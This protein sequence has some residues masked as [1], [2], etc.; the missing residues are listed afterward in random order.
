[1][2]PLELEILI[3]CHVTSTQHPNLD[4]PA[5]KEGFKKF[6]A[7]GIIVLAGKDCY[8]LTEKGRAWLETILSIPY[9][10]VWLDKREVFMSENELCW[11]CKE[12]T[13]RKGYV[14]L[15]P[16]VHCHHEP[17]EK[18]KC[19][20]CQDGVFAPLYRPVRMN[21]DIKA[22]KFCPECGRKP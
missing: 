16:W 14:R 2:T 21:A 15:N 13:D 1:M 6:K 4:A 17:K 3:H 12:A 5:V 10:S 7:D 8:C 18:S 9:P 19:E 22:S 20:Q 11:E